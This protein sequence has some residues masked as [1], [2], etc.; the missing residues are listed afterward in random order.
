MR[1]PWYFW[2]I[3][4]VGLLYN[5]AGVAN[6]VTQMDASTALAESYR[7]L[8]AD[9]PLWATVG[10]AIAVCAGALAGLLLLLRKS[11]A[12]YVFIGSLVGAIVT[13]I[14]ALGTNASQFVIGN[15]VQLLVTALL[16]WYAWHAQRKGWIS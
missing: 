6:F 3:G 13:M 4:G 10:F 8:V 5:I 9:R 14:H 7:A 1:V 15:L 12:F 16:I 2:V 11:A